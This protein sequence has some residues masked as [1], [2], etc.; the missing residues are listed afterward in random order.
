MSCTGLDIQFQIT[1]VPMKMLSD[2]GAALA[3]I[4]SSSCVQ[5]GPI[6]NM[7]ATEDRMRDKKGQVKGNGRSNANLMG[8]A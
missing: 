7:K 4:R 1:S 8:N 3:G 5:V 6:D 2:A